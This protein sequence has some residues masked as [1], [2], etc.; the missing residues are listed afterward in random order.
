MLNTL[1]L[2]FSFF[3]GLTKPVITTNRSQ[4]TE[5]NKKSATLSKL[6]S[7]GYLAYKSRKQKGLITNEAECPT[8]L[9]GDEWAL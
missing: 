8:I 6:N 5:T 1:K 3:T 4:N 7:L 2:N 9:F